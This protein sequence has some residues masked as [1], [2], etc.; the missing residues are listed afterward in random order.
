[1]NETN[2]LSPSRSAMSLKSVFDTEH[3]IKGIGSR[4]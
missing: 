1:L 4:A 2:L 3:I